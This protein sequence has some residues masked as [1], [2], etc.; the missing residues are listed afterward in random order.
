[1]K[2]LIS[3]AL[4]FVICALSVFAQKVNDDPKKAKFI[5]SDID[6]FWRAFD[7]AAKEADREKKIAI[8]Q[9]EYLDKGSAGLKDFIRMR[10]KSAKDLTETVESLPRFYASVRQSSLR[11]R[12]M[13]KQ[14]RKAFV[15]FKKIYPEAVFPDVYFVIGITNTGGTASGNGLLVGTELY[16]LTPETPRDEFPEAF[17]K[18]APKDMSE[19]LLREMTARLLN[20]ML[21]PIEKVTPLVAHESCHFNQN[22]P[23]LMTLLAKSVQ[24]GACDFIA[25]K[26]AGET[27]NVEQKIYGDRHEAELWKEFEAQMTDADHRNWMYNGITSANRPPDMGYYMGYKISHAYYQNAKDKRQAIRDILA[28]KDFNAFL[29]KSRYREK[30][31]KPQQQ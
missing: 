1:M 25:E 21:K 5:T 9:T 15:K 13:E 19:Q 6:N 12:E 2:N 28:T 31:T 16:G 26:T 14:M 29:E 7:L 17:R 20:V 23:E 10:I 30:F 3:I 4:C 22:Y 11:V 24:E 8:Y 27:L 18:R